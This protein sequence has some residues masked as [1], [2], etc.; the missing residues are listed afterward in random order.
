MLG[1]MRGEAVESALAP[2]CIEAMHLRFNESEVRKGQIIFTATV[3]VVTH[4]AGQALTDT[5]RFVR[6]Y[7]IC[8]RLRDFFISIRFGSMLALSSNRRCSSFQE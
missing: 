3:E 8:N 4:N 7:N 2:R 5:R 1:F 6:I